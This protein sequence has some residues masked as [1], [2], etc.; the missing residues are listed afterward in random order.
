MRGAGGLVHTG[1]VAW[2]NGR[3]VDA[4]SLGGEQRQRVTHEVSVA[5]LTLKTRTSWFAYFC[6]QNKNTDFEKEEEILGL[7]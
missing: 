1:C 2:L 5:P 7:G 6:T 3:C 4:V